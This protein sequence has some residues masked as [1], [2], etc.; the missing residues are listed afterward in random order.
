LAPANSP[1]VH[2]RSMGAILV[3]CDNYLFVERSNNNLP[4]QVDEITFPHRQKVKT[5]VASSLH[6]AAP[7]THAAACCVSRAGVLATVVRR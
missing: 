2:A 3:E 5:I 1:H 4:Q 6:F 7:K